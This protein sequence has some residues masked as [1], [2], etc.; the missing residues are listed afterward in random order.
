MS[1]TEAAAALLTLGPAHGYELRTLLEAELGPT[2]EV[3]ASN[4]YLVLGRMERDGLVER[5]RVEQSG[6]PD[7]QL[8]KLTPKGAQLASRWLE[9]PGDP[10]EFLLKIAIVRLARPGW[11]AE[12]AA[13]MAAQ[14]SAALAQLRAL[15]AEVSGGVQLEAINLEIGVTQARLRWLSGIQHSAPELA[16]R[17]RGVRPAR[18]RQESDRLA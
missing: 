3:R 2:W 18:P 11:L 15:R 6:R 17:Q 1:L 5:E 9:E 10:S 14:Q 8:L 7:R 4:L 13:T 16:N 12:L